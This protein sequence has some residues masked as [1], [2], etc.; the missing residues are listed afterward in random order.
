LDLNKLQVSLKV[1][2][3]KRSSKDQSKLI[4]YVDKHRFCKNKQFSRL[5]SEK[6]PTS[7]SD[8]P[9]PEVF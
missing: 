6:A 4:D 7:G 9:T 2:Q 1:K 5:K 8:I 3:L